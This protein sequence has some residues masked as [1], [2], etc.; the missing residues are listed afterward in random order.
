MSWRTGSKLF[1]EIWPAIKANITDQ[2]ERI[3]F[4]A[5]LIHVFVQEDMDTWEIEDVD[6]D[7]RKAIVQAGC[8]ICEPDRYKDE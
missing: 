6:P 4:T 5:A 1:L 3:E 8:E 2:E 7:I